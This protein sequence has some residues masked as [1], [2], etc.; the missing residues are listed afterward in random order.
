MR[1]ALLDATGCSGRG[2]VRVLPHHARAR[3]VA[4]H[5]TLRVGCEFREYTAARR[6]K[7]RVRK[8]NPHAALEDYLQVHALSVPPYTG[9]PSRQ[10]TSTNPDMKGMGGVGAGVGIQERGAG[11]ERDGRHLPSTP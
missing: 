4:R 10:W 8:E 9:A 5:S 6:L 2:M 11:G 7:M 1:G 3:T